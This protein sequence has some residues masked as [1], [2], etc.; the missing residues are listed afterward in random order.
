MF[1]KL[2]D[3][4]LAAGTKDEINDILY[5]NGGTDRKRDGVDLAYQHETLTW[6]DHERLFQMAAR[7]SL[8]IGACEQIRQAAEKKGE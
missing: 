4:I 1:K 8:G 2:F 7:I 5:R 3:E 6:A